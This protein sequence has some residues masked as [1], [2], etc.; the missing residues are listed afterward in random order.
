MSAG[1]SHLQEELD[2]LLDGQLPAEQRPRVEAHLAGCVRCRR[3]FEALR[4]ARHSVRGQLSRHELPAGLNA[5]IAAAL[6]RVDRKV[7]VSP[8]RR[9]RHVLAALGVTLAA[10]LALLFL[11]RTEDEDFIVAVAEDLAQ[12]RSSQL[13]LDLET[14]ET[15][16]LE[17][18]F[19]QA[20][21]GFDARVFDFGMMAYRLAGGSVNRIGGR[22]TALFAYRGANGRTLVCQMYEG[23]LDDLP[24]GYEERENNGI[25]FRVYRHAGLT[26]VFWQEGRVVCVLASD[27][28]VEETI[29]L[30]FAKAVR[31]AP[32]G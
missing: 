16:A 32:S 31:V 25:E 1:E 7:A 29:Q 13:R 27:A 3:E 21:I 2:L 12:F 18:Y 17:Q 6:D 24:D 23:V 5:R 9:R 28:T 22:T 14:A 30:A 8:R 15:A 20:G 11:P 10:M 19:A 4:L 26:L